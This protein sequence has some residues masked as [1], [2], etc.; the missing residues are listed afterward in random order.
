MWQDGRKTKGKREPLRR[1][2]TVEEGQGRRFGPALLWTLYS[3]MFCDSR[4]L[5]DTTRGLMCCDR[6]RP[7]AVDPHGAG[8]SLLTFRSS[9][10]PE[11]YPLLSMVLWSLSFCLPS[12]PRSVAGLD[13]EPDLVHMEARTADG[14]ECCFCQARPRETCLQLSLLPQFAF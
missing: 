14:C 11:C 10:H 5:S 9:N 1:C 4:Q 3:F 6:Y 2:E 8:Q 13:K 12:F 7:C